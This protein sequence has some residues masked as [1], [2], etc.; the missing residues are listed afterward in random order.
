MHL[1]VLLVP[2]SELTEQRP[3]R[4][5]GRVPPRESAVEAACLG[6]REVVDVR[7][8]TRWQGETSLPQAGLLGCPELSEDGRWGNV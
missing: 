4:P 7:G 1:T 8:W 3:W 5:D 2:V 6:A